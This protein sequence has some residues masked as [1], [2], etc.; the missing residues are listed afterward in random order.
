MKTPN[1]NK[2]SSD[3]TPSVL[4]VNLSTGTYFFNSQDFIDSG[5]DIEQV[6]HNEAE[7]EAAIL[8]V[9]KNKLGFTWRF[10]Q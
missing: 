2:V 9:I 4:A 6:M 5:V 1:T 10:L 7:F 8:R 3:S